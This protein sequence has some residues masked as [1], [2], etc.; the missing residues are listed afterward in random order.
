MRMASHIGI[1]VPVH[2]LVY[3]IDGTRTYFIRRFDRGPHKKKLAVEDFS[4]AMSYT[5]KTKYESSMEQV[6]AAVEK[7]TTFPLLEKHKLFSRVLFC[8]LTGNADMHLKNFSLI[9]RDSKYELSPRQPTQT[10]PSMSTV[11]RDGL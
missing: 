4:Q 8:F 5:R 7:Y 11:V 9:Y 10:L 3:C 1:E 2:G 6:A